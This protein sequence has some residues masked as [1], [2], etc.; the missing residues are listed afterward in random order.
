M[1]RVN[2]IDSVGYLK[3]ATFSILMKWNQQTIADGISDVKMVSR[4]ERSN[5]HYSIWKKRA[6]IPCTTPNEQDYLYHV[7]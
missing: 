5:D 7:W 3:S 1:H 4:T 6:H 2:T